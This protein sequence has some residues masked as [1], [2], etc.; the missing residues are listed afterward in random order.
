MRS[1]FLKMVRETLISL[2]W[3]LEIQTEGIFAVLRRLCPMTENW[4]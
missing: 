4:M 1:A 3:Y 2:G